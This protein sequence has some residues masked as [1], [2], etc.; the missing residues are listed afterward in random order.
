[1]VFLAHW[2]A[3]ILF[4]FDS[5]AVTSDIFA[6]GSDTLIKS[7]NLWLSCR[8]SPC[9]PSFVLGKQEESQAF[10]CLLPQGARILPV[11]GQRK[12]ALP[13]L[14]C[15][16]SLVLVW[17]GLV[18]LFGWM[19]RW[20]GGAEVKWSHRRGSLCMKFAQLQAKQKEIAH[21]HVHTHN[22]TTTQPYPAHWILLEFLFYFFVPR[23][24]SFS[25]RLLM[26]KLP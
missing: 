24:F 13:N 16:S 21:T 17:L 3:H 18:F 6:S 1:M 22:R 11:V 9:H 19:V 25:A 26:R 8:F 15:W 5:G 7:N 12:S 4:H 20:F 14:L 2:Y 23:S 10:L